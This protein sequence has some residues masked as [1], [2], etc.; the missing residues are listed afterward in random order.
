M[1]G[2]GVLPSRFQ[3]EHESH[4]P[5]PAKGTDCWHHPERA[6]ALP[7][8]R[9]HRCHLLAPGRAGTTSPRSLLDAAHGVEAQRSRAL[10]TP[11][12]LLQRSPTSSLGG[13]WQPRSARGSCCWQR[14][15]PGDRPAMEEPSPS[16]ERWVRAHLLVLPHR[17][18]PSR[19]LS[20][21]S[22]CCWGRS[23]RDFGTWEQPATPRAPTCLRHP[24]QSKRKTPTEANQSDT[25]RSWG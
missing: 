15:L 21:G 19:R 24:R 9:A 20:P 22:R 14:S 23:A 18:A 17:R 5:E 3:S 8:G 16:W 2:P 25:S 10:P 13:F 4:S 1:A 12:A 11:Q 6:A 7:S